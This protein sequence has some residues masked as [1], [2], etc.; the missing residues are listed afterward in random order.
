MQLKPL[1]DAPS[2]VS[3]RKTVTIVSTFRF[4]AL[5]GSTPCRCCEDPPIS[6]LEYRHVTVTA[7]APFCRIFSSL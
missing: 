1:G 2:R 3:L 5:Q 6:I 7:N 4:L